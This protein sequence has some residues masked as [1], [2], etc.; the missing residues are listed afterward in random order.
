MLGGIFLHCHVCVCVCVCFVWCVCVC[1]CE[2]ERER[3]RE[4]VWLGMYDVTV[5]MVCLYFC[6][7]ERGVVCSLICV[8]S[9]VCVC[10]C[11]CVGGRGICVKCVVILMVLGADWQVPG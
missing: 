5:T 8:Y 6:T 4:R 7:H 10:V 9:G 11:I 3:E 1:V 2:R